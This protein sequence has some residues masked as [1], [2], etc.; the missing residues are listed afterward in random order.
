MRGL[1]RYNRM[2]LKGRQHMGM[3]GDREGAGGIRDKWGGIRWCMKQ[4]WSM[5][6]M[7]ADQS[8]WEDG[9]RKNETSYCCDNC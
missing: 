5:C 1:E 4:G 6:D 2:D 9:G 7:G 3:S 8:E